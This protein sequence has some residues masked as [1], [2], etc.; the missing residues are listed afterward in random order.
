MHVYYVL[1]LKN[2]DNL[3]SLHTDPQK[4]LNLYILTLERSKSSS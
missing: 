1:V 3:L 2:C 4:L